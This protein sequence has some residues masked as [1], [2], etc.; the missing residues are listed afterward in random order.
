MPAFKGPREAAEP[1]AAAPAPAV[2]DGL[3]LAG[4]CKAYGGL[5]GP[6]VPALTD[7][8]LSLPGGSVVG[9]AGPN[10]AGKST[11][12][13]ILT[14]FLA[15]TGGTARI[16]GLPPREYASRR[17]VAYLPELV[18]LPPDWTVTAALERLGLLG[19]LA[20]APL[21]RRVAAA[22]A[23]MGLADYASA[24]VGR[25]SKGTL[26][27]L[28][29][30]QMLLSDSA[31]MVFD[32]PSNGLDPVWLM[33]FRELVRG[34][35]RPDRLIVIASHNLDELDRL[36]DSV[37]I[38]RQGRLE[39]V[40]RHALCAPDAAAPRVFRLKLLKPCAALAG[41]FPGAAPVAGR[42]TEY[43]LEAGAVQLNNG[44]L[45]LLGAGAVILAL[46]PE[47]SGLER[48]F[49]AAVEEPL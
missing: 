34:L 7:V 15:P 31:L 3:E 5:F 29:I 24:V 22:A 46:Q 10:G 11:L 13:S 36:T 6:V 47:Q 35:R 37:A 26:Q 48:A 25:L 49:S 20:G 17:G 30:A 12:L 18:R 44:L 33:R 43:L 16:Y 19:G 4:V 2:Y 42:E 45:K 1:P 21:A 14:G 27:R 28:G 41:V 8:T 9:V 40:V 39:R 23:E 38:L 32:E